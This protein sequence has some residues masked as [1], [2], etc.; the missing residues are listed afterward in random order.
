[1]TNTS[2]SSSA[3]CST[4]SESS[5][6]H[7]SGLRVCSGESQGVAGSYGKCTAASGA[8]GDGVAAPARAPRGDP[9]CG[10][11]LFD[12][13]REPF[14]PGPLKRGY[15][16]PSSATRCS[17]IVRRGE[18]RGGMAGVGAAGKLHAPSPP[19]KLHDIRLP[20]HRRHGHAAAHDLGVGGEVGLHTEEPR[21]ASRA[22]SEA[23]D[24]LVENKE[25]PVRVVRSRA[26][27][28]NSRVAGRKP[29]EPRNGSKMKQAIRLPCLANCFS[30]IAVSLKR[31]TITSSATAWG[32]PLLSCCSKLWRVLRVVVHADE[33][34]RLRPV[35]AAP[36]LHDRFPAG[37]SPGEERCVHRCQGAAGGEADPLGARPSARATPPHAPAARR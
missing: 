27:L 28:R 10:E 19:G 34:P 35:P 15:T 21:D 24:H 37:E 25:R 29:P 33:P 11:R 22:E 5:T 30:S 8:C 3:S 16:S 20:R 1:M 12:C 23:R 14:P 26:A 17:I 9:R 2:S 13:L 7:T 31:V 32:R 18:H 4:V 36:H 6:S